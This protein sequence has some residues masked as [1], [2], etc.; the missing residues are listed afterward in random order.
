MARKTTITNTKS[1]EQVKK[2]RYGRSGK[3]RKLARYRAEYQPTYDHN[4]YTN[5]LDINLSLNHNGKTVD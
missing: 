1:F 4:D 5:L 2:C 3:C